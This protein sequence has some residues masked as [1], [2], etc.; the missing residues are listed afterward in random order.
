MIANFSNIILIGMAGAG[1]STIG[2]VLAGLSGKQFLDTDDL[3]TL[4]TGMALQDYL[5]QVGGKR[6]QQI[7]EQILLG[8]DPYNHIIATGGSAVYSDK[9]MTH[10][11]TT[12]PLILLKVDL[13]TLKSG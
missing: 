12:G 3:I 7:E 10:L 13:V 5:D 8:L 2:R 9:G 11:Q 6:F 4:Q 1:K